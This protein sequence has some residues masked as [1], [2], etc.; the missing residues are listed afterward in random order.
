MTSLLKFTQGATTDLA[1][2]AVA[3]TMTGGVVNVTNGDNTGVV[4]W[5]YELLYVPPGSSIPLVTQ[6][7]GVTSTFSFAQPDRPGSYRVR[8]TTLDASGNADVDIRCFCVPF[9]AF[10]IIM[11]PYQGNPPPLPAT[12]AGAKPNEMNLGGSLVGYDGGMDDAAKLLYRAFYEL[13]R[14]LTLVAPQTETTTTSG[15]LTFA[16]STRKRYTGGTTLNLTFSAGSAVDGAEEVMFI[17]AG[18]VT[19]LTISSD[20]DPTGSVVFEF[21]GTGA[22]EFAATYRSNGPHIISILRKVTD[23]P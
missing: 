2:R 21:D 10:G 16:R 5:K 20:L 7:P 15:V 12:G 18:S 3:G 13:D 6:G 14:V 1:G 4:S 9:S 23:L 22:Y 11:P 8:L 17:P 19:T